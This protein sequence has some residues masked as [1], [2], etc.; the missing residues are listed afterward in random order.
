MIA[1]TVFN[2]MY[3]Y[4]WPTD[5]FGEHDGVQKDGWQIFT[6]NA[7]TFT[8]YKMM[9]C[10]RK[11]FSITALR[12]MVPNWMVHIYTRGLATGSKRTVYKVASLNAMV[13]KVD[14]ALSY[15][16]W[17]SMATVLST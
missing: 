15:S 12:V 4:G 16:R 13:L 5:N 6:I 17:I 10:S 14:K 3:P 11:I 1:T 7:T 9:G 8:T 2:T